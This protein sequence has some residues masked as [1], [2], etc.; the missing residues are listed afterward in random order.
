MKGI[1]TV[2][3]VDTEEIIFSVLTEDG[4]R[5]DGVVVRF[6]DDDAPTGLERL[7]GCDKGDEFDVSVD[8]DKFW[9][10][11]GTAGV[12][13]LAILGRHKKKSVGFRCRE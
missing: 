3:F 8:P 4:Q 7:Q 10:T 13:I 11:R 9:P 2:E 1:A 12:E 6:D 5:C